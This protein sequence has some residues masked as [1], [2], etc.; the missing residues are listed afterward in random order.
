LSVVGTEDIHKNTP[1]RKTDVYLDVLDII[2]TE[3]VK[4][5]RTEVLGMEIRS[6]IE[7]NIEKRS[8]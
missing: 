3:R 8:F 6:L 2:P 1:L 4:A 5:A 7:T